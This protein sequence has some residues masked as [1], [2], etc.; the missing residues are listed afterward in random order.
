MHNF[1]YVVVTANLPFCGVVYSDQCSI[2]TFI[3]LLWWQWALSC[4]LRAFTTK[5]LLIPGTRPKSFIFHVIEN[6]TRRKLLE[7]FNK[8]FLEIYLLNYFI[9]SKKVSVFQLN[10][11]RNTYSILYFVQNVISLGMAGSTYFCHNPENWNLPRNKKWKYTNC[12]WF[13]CN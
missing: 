12:V 9:L 7:I 1:K 13:Q 11:S 8:M 10:I 3:K 6:Q 5:F 4:P 2:K